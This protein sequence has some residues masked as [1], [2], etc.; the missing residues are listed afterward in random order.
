MRWSIRCRIRSF[1]TFAWNRD[2]ICS[3]KWNW[4][5][6]HREPS[7]WPTSARTRS[8]SGRCRN[9]YL[10]RSWSST[11]NYKPNPLERGTKFWMNAPRCFNWSTVVPRTPIP[12]Y[13]MNLNHVERNDIINFFHIIVTNLLFVHNLAS[14]FAIKSLAFLR[15]RALLI[16][17]Y[18][19]S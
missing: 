3:P 10:W 17:P 4:I 8:A 7:P 16:D 15:R 12:W 13:V 18:I 14:C 6:R 11:S 19:F 2:A 5:R 9:I 1:G